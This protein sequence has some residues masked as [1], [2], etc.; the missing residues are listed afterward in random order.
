MILSSCS[1]TPQIQ[2]IAPII[3][4]DKRLTPK[5]TGSAMAPCEKYEGYESKNVK[6]VLSV[7]VRNAE[8]YYRCASGKNE[9]ILFIETTQNDS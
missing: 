2:L 7:I 3:E 1:T 4:N 8:R 9:A 6:E 5:P